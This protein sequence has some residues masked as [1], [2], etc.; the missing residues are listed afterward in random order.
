MQPLAA[1]LTPD[2]MRELADYYAGLAP[3]QLQSGGSDPALVERGRRLAAE[4]LPSS[5]VAPCSAC[6]NN[7]GSFPRL[8]G[9]YAAYIA[10]QLRLWKAGI[11]SSADSGAVMMP[12]GKGLSDEDIDAVA[13]YFAALPP[14]PG[15]GH[16]PAFAGVP[17][18]MAAARD[19]RQRHKK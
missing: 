12:I 3:P 14:P 7:V 19:L 17:D 11:G 8:A 15:G 1:D 2:D 16:Y 9:Q 5:G 18:G 4:G 13:S 6:H 10:G